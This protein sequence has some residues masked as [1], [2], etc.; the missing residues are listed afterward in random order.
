MGLGL[1]DGEKDDFELLDMGDD[2]KHLSSSVKLDSQDNSIRQRG[3][4][5]TKKGG[6]FK[7]I[8]S[9]KRKDS[10]NVN[11][12]KIEVIPDSKSSGGGS[13]DEKRGGSERVKSDSGKKSLKSANSD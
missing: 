11:I 3:N 2:E 13:V 10:D 5:V 1:P 12:T 6:K 7:N 9:R 4:A 8:L